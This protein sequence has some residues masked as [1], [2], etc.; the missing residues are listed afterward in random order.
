[1]KA[2]NNGVS[3]SVAPGVFHQRIALFRVAELHICLR[4]TVILL[5]RLLF[6]PVLL[7]L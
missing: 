3:H 5:K 2:K 6:L 1:M 4:H 7:D